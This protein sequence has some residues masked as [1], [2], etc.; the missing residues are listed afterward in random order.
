M[1]VDCQRMAKTVRRRVE[2]GKTGIA[3]DFHTAQ[4][5]MVVHTVVLGSRKS[6][7]D[8]KS[9]AG[10]EAVN[11]VHNPYHHFLVAPLHPK[12][13]TVRSSDSSSPLP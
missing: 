6:H 12:A 11:A 2:H 9:A 5:H 13:A 8:P 1:A 3:V 7:L 10:A 4:F